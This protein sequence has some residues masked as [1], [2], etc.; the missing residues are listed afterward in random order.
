[1]KR[2]LALLLL[3]CSLTHAQTPPPPQA[4]AASVAFPDPGSGNS[5]Q[6]AQLKQQ[7]AALTAQLQSLPVSSVTPAPA[8]GTEFVSVKDGHLWLNG[9]RET[10][11]GVNMDQFAI[12]SRE[13]N[14]VSQRIRDAIDWTFANLARA[15]VRAI[16]IHGLGFTTT[17]NIFHYGNRTGTPGFTTTRKLDPIFMESFDYFWNSMRKN[18]I[19]AVVTLE[20]RRQLVPADKPEWPCPSFDECTT[21]RIP[22][23]GVGEMFPWMC[24]DPGL[25]RLNSEF[26]TQFLR[27]VNP[28]TGLAIGDDPALMAVILHN[29]TSITKTGPG[30][31]NAYV[32]FPVLSQL[33]TD[34]LNAYIKSHGYAR[35]NDIKAPEWQRMLQG[36][37][38]QWLANEV[39]T[40]RA[41]TKALIIAGTVFGDQQYAS[42]VS[43][44]NVGDVMDCHAY[45]RGKPTEPNGLVSNLN[46]AAKRSAFSADLAA[47]SWGKPLFCTEWGPVAQQTV[48]RD[49]D[50]DRAVDLAAVVD[51]SIVQDADAIFLYSWG[52]GS[53]FDPPN[54]TKHTVYDFRDD[55]VLVSGFPQQA[56]R[57]HDLSQ[58]QGIPTQ[59]ITLTPEKLWGVGVGTSFVLQGP[60]R[61]PDV[62]AVDGK[63]RVRMVMP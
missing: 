8:I 61:D 51:A 28:L 37:E 36:I 17:M 63:T 55:A 39:P 32:G 46:P 12:Q 18:N 22:G 13:G 58:R 49:P 43:F 38:Q 57:F 45:S 42:L 29:E 26:N 52:H 60:W 4:S 24:F 30:G 40:V 3:G 14:G 2:I 47:C 48:T 15:G 23:K 25:N 27:H 35:S 5:A 7:I 10:F 54:A 44:G 9:K 50:A 59:S 21:L 34:T 31:P 62:A 11:F 19:R 16:R 1:M 6:A 20:F 41:N 33:W 53:L 56:T